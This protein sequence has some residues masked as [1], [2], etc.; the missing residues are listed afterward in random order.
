L[1]PSE[2]LQRQVSHLAFPFTLTAALNDQQQVLDDAADACIGADFEHAGH[3]KTGGRA[4]VRVPAQRRHVVRDE[5]PPLIGS[6]LENLGVIGSRQSDIL[7][8]GDVDVRL[9]SKQAT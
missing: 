4:V 1:T 5:H 9:S 2:L 7:N 6:P 8:S 3:R